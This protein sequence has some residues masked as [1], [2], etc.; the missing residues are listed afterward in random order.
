M[1]PRDAIKLS[2]FVLIII[3]VIGGFLHS[4][5]AN[6]LTQAQDHLKESVESTNNDFFFNPDE[7]IWFARK[8]SCL[9]SKCRHDMH[10]WVNVAMEKFTNEWKEEVVDHRK[11]FKENRENLI[12]TIWIPLNRRFSYFEKFFK[13][14][15]LVFLCSTVFYCN[16][17]KTCI[18]VTNNFF[19]K[20]Y[21][22]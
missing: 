2:I 3:L 10:E 22:A 16:S 15:E 21:V 17:S 1:S 19:R 9:N 5:F 6:Y 20:F 12:E 8:F 18:F 13:F 4:F 7:A 11:K 14:L